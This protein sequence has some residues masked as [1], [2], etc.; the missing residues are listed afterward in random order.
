MMGDKEEQIITNNNVQE[1]GAMYKPSE[2]NSAGTFPQLVLET[3]AVV[4]KSQCKTRETKGGGEK[5]KNQ[6]NDEDNKGG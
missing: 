1:E 6:V 5:A 3:S 2:S 4:P